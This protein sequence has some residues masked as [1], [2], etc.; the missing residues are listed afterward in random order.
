[1][2]PVSSVKA[3]ARL[4]R[5]RDERVDKAI[6]RAALE[7]MAEGGIAELRMDAVAERAGV[8]KAA[9]YRRF[10]SKDE[11]V[12]S[13]VGEIV[14][15]E[16]AIPDTG[17]T[18]RD[19]RVLMD[20]AVALYGRAPAGRLMPALVEAMRRD[21]ELGAAIREWFLAGRRAALAEVVRRGIERGDLDPDLDIELTLDILAGPLFYR[22]L[23]TGGPLDDRLAAGVVDLILKGNAAPRRS[24]ARQPANTHSNVKTEPGSVFKKKERSK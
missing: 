16:I 8:G 2:E 10:R 19:L 15:S 6:L 22:L 11:L 24:R 14:S 23:I 5:P 20:E 12:A 17:S 3:T 7:L 13:A 9:I 1:M 18:E 4:G 21:P